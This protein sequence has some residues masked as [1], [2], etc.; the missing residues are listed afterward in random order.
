MLT[1]AQLQFKLLEPGDDV[2]S[3]LD[4]III[5]KKAGGNLEAISV[6]LSPDEDVPRLHSIPSQMLPFKN[7]DKIVG[8]NESRLIVKREDGSLEILMPD[9]KVT[10]KP[11]PILGEDFSLDDGD[12]VIRL[13]AH[14]IIVQRKSGCVESFIT[15]L[16]RGN[17]P[18]FKLTRNILITHRY[19]S[20][21]SLVVKESNSSAEFG[22]F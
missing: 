1:E 12:K 7:G 14:K 13:D 6:D 2:V 19:S 8:S 15:E 5:V 9:E 16:C 18:G 17:D 20:T 3:Y 11:Y 21:V 10:L 4:N 22:T